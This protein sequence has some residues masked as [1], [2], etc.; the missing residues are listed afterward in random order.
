MKRVLTA[1]VLIPLVLLVVYYAPWWLF[2]L[3]VTA[4]IVLALHE[5]LAI[6]EAAGLKPFKWLTYLASVAPVFL[7]LYWRWRGQDLPFESGLLLSL[8]WEKLIALAPIIFGVPLVFR[9]DLRM[10][11]AS[12]AS[13][14]FGVFYI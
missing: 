10:G 8:S 2:D 12:V 14:L 6:A 3:L 5:Y 7:S 4:I 11:L 9:K 1:V 13:S